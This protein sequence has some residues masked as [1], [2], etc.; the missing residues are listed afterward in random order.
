MGPDAARDTPGS[1]R[2]GGAG[3]ERRCGDA[4]APLGCQAGEFALPDGLHYLNCA[5]MSPLARTVEAAGLDGF[6]RL[7]A[8]SRIEPS[9]FFEESDELRR[10]FAA[11]VGV[12]EPARVALIPSASYGLAIAARN[13]GVD[14]GQNLVLAEDQFPSNVYAWR[15][16]ADARGA[17]LRFVGPGDGGGEEGAGRGERWNA[18]I[19]E[20]IDGATAGVALPHVH[21]TDGTLFELESVRRRASEVGAA[22]IVDGTQSVGALPFEVGRIRPDALVCAGYKWML[23]PYSIGVAYLGPRFDDADPLE[24]TWLGRKGSEDFGGLVDYE[25]EYQPGAIRHDMGERSNPVTVPMQTAALRLL[26]D[27]GVERIQDYCR[28][29]TR[30][31]VDEAGDLGMR[32]EDEAWRASHLFGLRLPTGARS[33]RLARELEREDVVVS[34]RGDAVRVSPHLYNDEGDVE[35]LLDV[36]RRRA[37]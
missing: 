9:D 16:L 6:R 34:V 5:Y 36:L 19:L 35:A 31:L 26:L 17:D 1:G 29:L 22:L 11:L 28:R 18:R 14:P 8:P 27:W 12:E 15:R 10:A 7:R 30:P 21:W 20:A 33:E 25:T 13:L 24:E 37:G 32:V 3:E 4:A 2:G 23:G